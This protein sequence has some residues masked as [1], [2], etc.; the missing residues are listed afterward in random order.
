LYNSTQKDQTEMEKIAATQTLVVEKLSDVGRK[1]AG[2]PFN[3]W[4][5]SD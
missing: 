4:K 3:L 2:I 1:R 5:L